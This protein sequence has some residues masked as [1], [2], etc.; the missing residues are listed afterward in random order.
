MAS[1]TIPIILSGAT[2]VVGT[3]VVAGLKPEYEVI[4]F[5]LANA[6]AK[7]IPLLLKGEVPTAPSS[8]LGSGN[9]STPPKAVVFGGAWDDK[10][11][12]DLR[13]A[14]AETPGTRRIPWLRVDANKPHPPHNGPEYGK[15]IMERLRG[16]LK[17]LESDGKLNEGDDTV[18]FF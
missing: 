6:G 2:E 15:H 12:A 11:I 5:T 18:H 8:A 10:S 3:R 14:A 4:H 13:K 1:R 16:L 7:E 9:W 17:E